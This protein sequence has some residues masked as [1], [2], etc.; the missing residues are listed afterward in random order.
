M[1]MVKATFLLPVR[2]ND[3]RSLRPEIRAVEDALIGTF[4]GY[5][6]T[7]PVSGVFRMADGTEV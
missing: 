4:S 5:T 1:A 6:S 3:G 7:A 2:D